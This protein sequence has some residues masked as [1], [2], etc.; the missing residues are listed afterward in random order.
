L[1][2]RDHIL[3]E[4][5]EIC[6]IPSG[7]KLS[8]FLLHCGIERR[9]RDELDVRCKHGGR[10]KAS[11]GNTHKRIPQDAVLLEDWYGNWELLLNDPLDECLMGMLLLAIVS[12]CVFQRLASSLH[13]D[14]SH[15]DCLVM[16]NVASEN[17]FVC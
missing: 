15:L 14:F 10:F 7:P 16:D 1:H 17:N 3:D 4:T 8:K 13:R 2:I 6:E 11:I 5:V 9:R 12:E